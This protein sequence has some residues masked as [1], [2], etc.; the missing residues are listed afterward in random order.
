MGNF[1]GFQAQRGLHGGGR[2]QKERL[3]ADFLV[4]KLSIWL[5]KW[6]F[7]SHSNAYVVFLLLF[8][9]AYHSQLPG[10]SRK[11]HWSFFFKFQHW[12]LEKL[13]GFWIIYATGW[14]LGFP[15][16]QRF[17]LFDIYMQTPCSLPA[18]RITLLSIHRSIICLF[19]VANLTS[20]LSICD[21]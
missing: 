1:S 4:Q 21:W 10:K 5:R 16:N 8:H 12:N 15:E 19:I 14:K 3:S 2:D 6:I 17:L 18:L 11:L 7:T 13:P 9:P 20:L